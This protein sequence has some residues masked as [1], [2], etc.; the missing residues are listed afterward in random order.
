ML[1]QQLGEEGCLLLPQQ[2]QQPELLPV[3]NA[4]TAMLLRRE[5]SLRCS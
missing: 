5:E 1:L 3:A 4:G 2:L